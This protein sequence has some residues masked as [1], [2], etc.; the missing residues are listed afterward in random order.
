MVA[1]A[2]NKEI[3]G[4]IGQLCFKAALVFVA[5]EAAGNGHEVVFFTRLR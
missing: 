2:P 3:L 5:F 4:K 1:G